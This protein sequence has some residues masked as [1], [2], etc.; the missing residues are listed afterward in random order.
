MIEIGKKIG[1]LTFLELAHKDNK[2]SGNRYAKFKCDCGNE[3]VTRLSKVVNG[4]T[5]SCG[6]LRKE[7]YRRLF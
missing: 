6:C 7:F 1:K 2:R 3:T 4:E 5:K